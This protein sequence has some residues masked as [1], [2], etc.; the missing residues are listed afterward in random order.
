MLQYETQ[1]VVYFTIYMIISKYF[2][3]TK[4]SYLFQYKN[5]DTNLM[6]EFNPYSY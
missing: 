5:P 1:D 6:M 3:T 2:K 4:V